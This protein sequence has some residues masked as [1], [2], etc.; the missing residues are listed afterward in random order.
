MF[1]ILDRYLGKTILGTIGITLFMLVSLSGI[2]RFI[3]QLR[4]IK[5]NYDALSAGLYALL[6]V[7]KDIELF[8]PMAALLGAL[9][10]LGMLASKSE[11]VVMETAGFSRIKIA[12]AVMKTAIPLVLLTMAIGEWVAPIGEQ[13]AR[14]MRSERTYGSSIISS[15][16]SVW[17]KDGSTFIHIGRVNSDNSVNNL[18]IY[19]VENDRLTKLTYAAYAYYKDRT[20][21]MM[22]VEETDL[23][24]PERVVGTSLLNKRWNTNVTPDKLSIVA[25]DPDSLS[26][27]GLYEY[28][29][30]L[31]STGQ[32]ASNYKLLFWKK[33]LKPLSVAVMTLMALSFIFGPLR[34]VSMGAR[35][36]AGITGGF[37]FYVADSVFSQ[38]SV[39]AGF[40]PIIGALLTSTVFLLISIFLLKKKR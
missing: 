3:D 21:T 25:L 7:P 2:I 12:K 35:V 1:G 26:A 20:W 13:T 11:L 27:S 30:Y 36:L 39:V 19:T 5:E 9:I 8:F 15:Q 28:T 31:E 34:S 38:L 23:S 24:N 17:A 22:Q 40:N 37:I 32:D 14:S 29:Q 33:L 6:M 18:N 10:G 16:G 4:K